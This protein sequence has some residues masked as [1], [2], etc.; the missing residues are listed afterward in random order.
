M[1]TGEPP[2]PIGLAAV[3]D[4][5]AAVVPKSKRTDVALRLGCT[6]AFSL[7]PLLEIPVAF[8]DMTLGASRVVKV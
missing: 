6:R 8:S 7:A 2:A 4:P 5:Y 1:D 3:D